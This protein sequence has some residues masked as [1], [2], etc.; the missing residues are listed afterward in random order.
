[1]MLKN[2]QTI[3]KFNYPKIL[4]LW[5]K[6]I[7]GGDSLQWILKNDATLQVGADGHLTAT[8]MVMM[9]DMMM[10]MIMTNV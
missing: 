1:M 5:H 4:I 2:R 10:I 9:I 8:V 3:S 7:P 6:T